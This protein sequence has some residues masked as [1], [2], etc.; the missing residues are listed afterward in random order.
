MR[1]VVAAAVF[2]LVACLV[3][4]VQGGDA[5]SDPFTSGAAYDPLHGTVPPSNWKW[6]ACY[7]TLSSDTT[8]A[9]AGSWKDFGIVT[10]S[11]NEVVVVDLHNGTVIQS[12]NL[13]LPNM[14]NPISYQ[15]LSNGVLLQ[16]GWATMAA[17]SLPDL[18]L[19]WSVETFQIWA[20]TEVVLS[21]TGKFF[22]INLLQGGTTAYPSCFRVSDGS[23]LWTSWGNMSMTQYVGF[24]ES[25]GILIT[26]SHQ[27]STLLLVAAV[28]VETGTYLWGSQLLSLFL[29]YQ[30]LVVVILPTAYGSPQGVTALNI[31][32]GAVTWNQPDLSSFGSLATDSGVAVGL[33]AAYW[34]HNGS[35]I[36]S[37]PSTI[38]NSWSLTALSQPPV[39]SRAKATF[40][41]S[42]PSSY[43][44]GFNY[45]IG[46][47][48]TGDLAP[49][50]VIITPS[51]N[52]LFSSDLGYYFFAVHPLGPTENRY[53]FH[54]FPS[55]L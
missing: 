45:T 4:T 47:V 41:Y 23:L 33:G 46:D 32:T 20:S 44:N 38:Y 36:W 51:G 13:S 34:L 26:Y 30:E 18:E 2:S 11:G 31:R 12:K 15:V 5:T 25:Q 10:S 9:F 28:E 43:A 39:G 22:C 7:G 54:A 1:A 55:N 53:C 40:L 35:C 52:Q 8:Y 42:I 17:W 14:F 3:R 21:T 29:V 27:F 49:T 50:T 16:L 37:T 19:I 6:R 48:M 24:H